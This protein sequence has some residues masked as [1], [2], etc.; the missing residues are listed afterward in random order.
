M[1]FYGISLIQTFLSYFV[2]KNEI[3]KMGNQT[4]NV[5]GYKYLCFLGICLALL[6]APIAFLSIGGAYSLELVSI[7]IAGFVIFD[8]FKAQA[9]RRLIA[10]AATLFVNVFVVAIFY[11]IIPAYCG[12][13]LFALTPLIICLLSFCYFLLKKEHN[14]IK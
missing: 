8:L 11:S 7:T 14:K 13:L 10:A 12:L 1:S 9:A 3:A 2:V 6:V 5:F 4:S